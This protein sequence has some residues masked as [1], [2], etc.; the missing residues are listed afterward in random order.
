MKLIC[1]CTT[2]GHDV[3]VYAVLNVNATRIQAWQEIRKEVT[4]A[5]KAVSDLFAV[6]VWA[7]FGPDWYWEHLPEN[8]SR[9]AEEEIEE[10]LDGNDWVSMPERWRGG[11][12]PRAYAEQVCMSATAESFSFTALVGEMPIETRRISWGELERVLAGENPWAPATVT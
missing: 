2:S 8:L 3:S 6:S 11:S 12:E 9:R 1:S 5:G 10:A 7:S 4:A